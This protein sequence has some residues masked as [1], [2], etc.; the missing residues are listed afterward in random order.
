MTELADE[1]RWVQ[2]SL[3]E[4][5]AFAVLYDHY[6]AR[7]Y[8][9]FR[10][11]VN[12]A[13]LADDL[14]ARTF[15]RTLDK[16]ASYRADRAP[17]AAWLFSIAR[18]TLTDHFRS[19]SRRTWL[20][21]HSLSEHAHTDPQPEEVVQEHEAHER[22]LVAVGRLGERERD[23]LALKFA[24]GLDNGQIAQLIGITDNHVAVILYRAVRQLKTMLNE[25]EEHDG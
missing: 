19:Q 3:D 7:I 18:H 23:V 14:T 9:Y 20:P 16:L 13:A 21:W 1:R 6:H 17:F 5:D 24:G 10:Y 4:P 12:D 15:E 11:R 8:N 2:R 22:L 25:S